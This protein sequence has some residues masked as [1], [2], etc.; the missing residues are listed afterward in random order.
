MTTDPLCDLGGL[1][2]AAR[3]GQEGAQKRLVELI[4]D[5]IRRLAGARMRHQRPGHTLQPTAL[6][7]EVVLKLL[8]GDTLEH[9]PNRGYLIAAACE[10]MKQVLADH[11]KRRNAAKRGGGRARVPLDE[12]LAYFEER[13][14]DVIALRDAVACLARE[15]PRSARI[16]DLRFFGGLTVP[17]VAKAMGVAV[18][19]VESDWRFA[20]ARLHDLLED[21]S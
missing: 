18:A 1:L 4:Y 10:A 19:T 12:A 3:A 2:D 7:H 21:E 6:V 14:L 20:R 13:K 5:E 8:Q 11:A 16:V 15:H 17:E 9:V